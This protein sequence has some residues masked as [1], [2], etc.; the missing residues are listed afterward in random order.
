VAGRI[1]VALACCLIPALCIAQTVSGA[2]IRVQN[3]GYDGRDR[4]FEQQQ[5]NTAAALQKT[6][7]GGPAYN[8]LAGTVNICIR[9][10]SVSDKP[11]AVVT[12]RIDFLGPAGG[13]ESS[14]VALSK[15]TFAKDAVVDCASGSPAVVAVAAPRDL[16]PFHVHVTAVTYVDGTTQ[17]F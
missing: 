14:E 13:V 17:R 3:A 5:K 7:T 2:P 9:F 15:G 10:E 6:Q 8:P 11:I 12:W 16:P 4:T 1:A